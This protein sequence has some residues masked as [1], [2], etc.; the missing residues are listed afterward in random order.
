MSGKVNLGDYRYVT[1]CCIL[2]N[3]AALLLCVEERTIVLAVI[4]GAVA[5]DDG[6]IALCCDG[7]ELGVLLYL[8][9]PTLV[10]G[11][12]PVETVEVVECEHVDEAL[13]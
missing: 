12:V 10:I 13:D 1:L 4:L 5:S 3:L 8:D 11:Q 9:A 7:S 6:L 2:Y